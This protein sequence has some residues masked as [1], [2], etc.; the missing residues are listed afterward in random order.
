MT[1]MRQENCI[2]CCPEKIEANIERR[3]VYV[4]SDPAW[5]EEVMVFEPLNP[6]VPGHL[7]VVPVEHC[8]DFGEDMDLVQ[9]VSIVASQLMYDVESANLI[10]SKGSAATQTVGHLHMHF[11]PRTEG[12][13]L[14]LPWTYQKDQTTHRCTYPGKHG[15]HMARKLIGLPYECPGTEE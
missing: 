4:G 2:F 6:V 13:G 15:P 11:V 8:S 1:T 7:L 9:A 3:L 10:T 14:L 12:D 5:A